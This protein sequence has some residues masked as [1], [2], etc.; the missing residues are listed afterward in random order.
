MKKLL[1]T[2]STI[3][4]FLFIGI[5][6]ILI[7]DHRKNV[8]LIENPKVEQ[9]SYNFITKDLMVVNVLLTHQNPNTDMNFGDSKIDLLD[10]EY[11]HKSNL[12]KSN[13]EIVKF[14]SSKRFCD[15]EGIEDS[16]MNIYL[17]NN[18]NPIGIDLLFF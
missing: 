15:L 13:F 9:S 2:I 1:I 3:L 5:I 4:L 7:V 14:L 10:N 6:T 8:I 16:I 18:V 17:K 11:I 12:D